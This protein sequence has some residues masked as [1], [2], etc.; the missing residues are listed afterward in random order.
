MQEWAFN[1]LMTISKKNPRYRER[2]FKHCKD[3][4]VENGIVRFNTD[5]RVFDIEAQ[6]Y[7]DSGRIIYE[8]F[9]DKD[10]PIDLY[11]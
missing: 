11:S 3:I 8:D 10:E 7:T 1:I 4:Q 9:M 2:L 6:A 5:S